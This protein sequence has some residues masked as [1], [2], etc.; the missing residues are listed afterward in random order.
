MFNHPNPTV[1]AAL[2]SPPALQECAVNH[3]KN[4]WHILAHFSDNILVRDYY[5]K[6]VYVH[7]GVKESFLKCPWS[8]YCSVGVKFLTGNGGIGRTPSLVIILEFKDDHR[9]FSFFFF[10]LYCCVD[11]P[12]LHWTTKL[13]VGMT[14]LK[15]WVQ[16]DRQK[17]LANEI[18]LCDL[19]Y[20]TH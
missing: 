13:N 8:V 15:N 14:N 5:A 17:G 3:L 2:R 19:G 9:V 6:S 12:N 18:C 16:G 4:E 1:A 11:K 10:F 7:R 20:E